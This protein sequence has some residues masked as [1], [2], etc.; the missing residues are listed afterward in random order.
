MAWDP[1]LEARRSARLLRVLG[2]VQLALGV[3][4]IVGAVVL[5]VLG[6]EAARVMPAIHSLMGVTF[7]GGGIASIRNAR[8]LESTR[9]RDSDQRDA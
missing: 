9:P 5:L 1:E 7:I 4:L 8:R 6:G 3:L 2:P